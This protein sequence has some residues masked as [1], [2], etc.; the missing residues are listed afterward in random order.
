MVVGA[1][2]LL[3]FQ[4]FLSLLDVF[5]VLGAVVALW[6]E[7]ADVAQA[8]DRAAA[9]GAILSGLMCS[10]VRGLRGGLLWISP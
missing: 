3:V 2:K 1:S 7:R 9:F 6:H 8:T 10:Y 5:E 4:C